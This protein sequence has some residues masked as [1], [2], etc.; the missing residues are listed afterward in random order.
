MLQL[1]LSSSLRCGCS[2]H[3]IDPGLSR[4][5]IWGEDDD[6]LPV[7]DAAAFARDL[8]DCAGVKVLPGSGH[9]PHLDNPAP[10]T[11]TILEF[12]EGLA[13]T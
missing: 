8:P 6:I 12:V 5:V 1:A 3:R 13:A 9:S 10:V 7:E 11:Q 2:R 4:L